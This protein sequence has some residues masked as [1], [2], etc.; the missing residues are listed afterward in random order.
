ML[1]FSLH[2]KLCKIFF[3]STEVLEMLFEARSIQE[4]DLELSRER[5]GK[6]WHESADGF[7]R[8]PKSPQMLH[9]WQPLQH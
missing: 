3:G 5:V 1:S 8:R 4:K 2:Y 7:W 6:T 9:L